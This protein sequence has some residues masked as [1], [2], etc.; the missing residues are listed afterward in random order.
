MSTHL[1]L[2]AIT[3]LMTFACTGD[4]DPVDTGGVTIDSGND[5][6]E[7]IDD[8]GPTIY[9]IQ[10]GIYAQ[11]STIRLEG[12]TVSS[13]DTG[14]GFF[15]TEPRGGEQSGLWVYTGV[16]DGM[17]AGVQQGDRIA[18]SG[19]IAE[20]IGKD[21]TEGITEL[22]LESIEDLEILGTGSLPEPA[23]LTT[24]QLADPAIA[25]LWESCLVAVED[26]I[27]TDDYLG[28]GEWMVDGSVVIDDMFIEGSAING[29]IIDRIAGPLYYS[30]G[31]FK[32]EPRDASDLVWT[33]PA[34]AC[35]EDL[36]AGDIVITEL[37][38]NPGVGPDEEAEWFE[39]YNASGQSINLK[40]LTIADNG[41]EMTTLRT[42]AVIGIGA[43]AVFGVGAM[44][45]WAY[46]DFE[47]DGWYSYGYVGLSNDGDALHLSN[48]TGILDSS[49]DYSTTIGAEGVAWQLDANS[50][51]TT[52]NDDA[53]HWC[54]ATTAMGTS[55]DFGSPREPNIICE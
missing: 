20:Y 29:E 51:D 31:S 7:W 5:T 23:E 34:S 13:P 39:V 45:G 50:L 28:Y 46:T 55:G 42:G 19:T 21:S 32:I 15:I 6:A 38:H 16:L 40:G 26:V 27:V 52:T 10:Q 17:A 49:A 35:V 36:V 44:E 48:N 30:Y 4:K 8:G 25:E 18:I 53:N 37:M 2:L 43:Y 47:P 9:E 14:Y 41:D 22:V 24:E 54:D 11:D 12:V 3:S 33:C 1:R